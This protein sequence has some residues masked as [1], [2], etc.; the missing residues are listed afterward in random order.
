MILFKEIDIDHDNSLTLNEVQNWFINSMKGLPF[1]YR[2]QINKFIRYAYK[3][4]DENGD[5]VIDKDEWRM[6]TP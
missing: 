6:M 1:S 5:G 4:V 3:K 2:T